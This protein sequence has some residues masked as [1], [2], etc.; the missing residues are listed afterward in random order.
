MQDIVT[1]KSIDEEYKGY[2]ANNQTTPFDCRA[3]TS[4][5]ARHG[6]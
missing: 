5:K 1:K 3:S 2:Y 6:G 4:L